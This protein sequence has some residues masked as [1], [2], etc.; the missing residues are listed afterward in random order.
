MKFFKKYRMDH[1]GVLYDNGVTN[2][3]ELDKLKASR[4]MNR[5]H[6]GSVFAAFTRAE[7]QALAQLIKNKK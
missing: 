5:D 7:E 2:M 3:P 4:K 1:G 6:T